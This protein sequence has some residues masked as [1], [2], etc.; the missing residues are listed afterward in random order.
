MLPDLE[1]IHLQSKQLV[2]SG[3][4]PALNRWWGNHRGLVENYLELLKKLEPALKDEKNKRIPISA[5]RQEINMLLGKPG[6]QSIELRFDVEFDQYLKEVARYISVFP[7][8]IRDRQPDSALI[9]KKT[10]SRWLKSCKRVK[11]ITFSIKQVPLRIKNLLRYISGKDVMPQS[12]LMR[13]VP[14]KQIVSNFLLNDLPANLLTSLIIPM[15]KRINGELRTMQ[16]LHHLLANLEEPGTKRDEFV[17]TFRQLT[18]ELR[19]QPVY[20][21]ESIVE[22]SLQGLRSS[23]EEQFSM[24]GTLELPSKEFSSRRINKR[25]AL[26]LVDYRRGVNNENISILLAFDEWSGGVSL[27]LLSNKMKQVV[28]EVSIY[29]ESRINLQYL[30]W[31][32]KVYEFIGQQVNTLDELPGNDLLP[33]FL[34]DMEKQFAGKLTGKLIPEFLE[35]AHNEEIVLK[36]QEFIGLAMEH[37][38]QIKEIVKV[39]AVRSYPQKMLS[40]GDFVQVRLRQL[41]ENDALPLITDPASQLKNQL[42]KTTVQALEQIQET[43]RIAEYNLET[44]LSLLDNNENLPKVR[45]IASEGLQRA[46]SRVHVVRENL[47]SAIAATQQTLV[48]SFTLFHNRLLTYQQ[49]ESLMDARARIVKAKA[50]RK[51]Q[52]L[53]QHFRQNVNTSKV[54]TAAYIKTVF[55]VVAS[56]YRRIKTQLGLENDIPVV[57]SEISDFLAE[58]ENAITRLPYVY[59]RLFV[60]S[61]LDDEKFFRGRTTELSKL[62]EAYGNWLAGRYAP[63]VIVGETGSGTTSLLNLFCRQ[64]ITG[65]RVNRI[66]TVVPV[67]G[68]KEFFTLIQSSFPGSSFSN[69]DEAVSFLNSL[70]EKQVIIFEGVHRL[71]LRTIYGF[72]SVRLFAQII[73]ATSRHIYWLTTANVYG[74]LYLKKSVHLHDFFGYIIELQT[75]SDSEIVDV[76]LRRHIA[77]GYNLRYEISEDGKAGKKFKNAEDKQEYLKDLYFNQLND[78][79]RSNIAISMLLWLRSAQ[80]I[81]GN[82]I[83]ISLPKGL[84]VSFI[85]TLSREKLFLLQALLVHDG[86]PDNVIALVLNYT[87]EKVRLMIIQLFDD[88]IVVLKRRLYVI[89]PLLYRQVTTILREV[90]LIH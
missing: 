87:P 53:R 15:L 28:H 1:N 13:K 26:F 85:K 3:I 33:G 46:L 5:Y 80:D 63:T 57:S 78:F 25:K 60:L 6:Y 47:H 9:I 12:P 66:E 31:V 84:K 11:K 49:G 37:S 2:L 86:L 52:H 38:A 48:N 58:T 69:F 39:P 14:V 16:E 82:E 10:D 19:R 75:L 45:K 71:F 41:V 4:A 17:R 7:L 77:S 61:P 40:L 67:T 90:N 70:P 73:S 81:Q 89:N 79:A 27:E 32:D 23:L 21:V 50:L 68:E 64:F 88:G 18:G 24:G 43:G 51:S 42:V 74:W 30:T 54:K 8:Y 56:Q 36:L 22:E 34:Q 29:L 65:I 72:Q 55:M 83:T 20:P 76:I 35:Q 59:Q 44:A 62:A